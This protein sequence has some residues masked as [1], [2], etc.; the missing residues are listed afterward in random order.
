VFV[1]GLFVKQ[2]RGKAK[3]FWQFVLEFSKD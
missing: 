1:I 3:V 2:Y